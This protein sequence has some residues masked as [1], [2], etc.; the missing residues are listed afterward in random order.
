[1]GIKHIKFGKYKLENLHD[2]NQFMSQTSNMDISEYEI[3]GKLF[4]IEDIKN[5]QPN[6]WPLI[7]LN[8][9]NKGGH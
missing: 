2:I 3:E 1:V 5:L 4:K 7:T 8:H 6:K 9:I